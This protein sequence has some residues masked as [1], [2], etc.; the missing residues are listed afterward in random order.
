MLMGLLNQ[1]LLQPYFVGFDSVRVMVQNSAILYASVW[2]VC[3]L[4]NNLIFLKPEKNFFVK[5][6]LFSFKIYYL[7]VNFGSQ[8]SGL[9][10]K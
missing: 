3:S 6:K 5:I 8:K 9:D 10:V 4:T 2:S 7:S 1:H